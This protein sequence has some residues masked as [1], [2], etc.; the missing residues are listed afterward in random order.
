MQTFGAD[1]V[2]RPL[3]AA[4]APAWAELTAAEQKADPGGEEYS[5]SE[6]AEELAVPGF[7]PATDSLGVFHRDTLVAV[8]LVY[9]K[10]TREP[11]LWY[12]LNGSVHPDHRRSGIGTALLRWQRDRVR[13]MHRDSGSTLPGFVTAGRHAE[14][15]GHEK[16]LTTAGMEPVRWFFDMAC[17]L[18][19]PLVTAPVPAGLRVED[20]P[21]SAD[22]AVRLAYV[23]TFGD[24][25]GSPDADPDYW[26]HNFVEA[27]I[28]RRDLSRLA[29]DGDQ[30]AGYV[31]CFR[32]A[33]DRD[34]Q[35]RERVWLGD[36]GVRRPWRRRGLAAALIADVLARC[37]AAGFPRA[38]LGMD[39][40]NPTGA[41][42]VY[43][44]AGFQVEHR[45]V[46]HG[47]RLPAPADHTW[48]T[49]G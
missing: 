44:R 22:E 39:A 40:D 2:H 23:E 27:G 37:A 29:Y 10:P 17:D 24:H 30:I 25:W 21:V 8:G 6:L 45:W 19:A 18:T 15:A 14:D 9:R 34:D 13:R 1:L 46:T 38:A 36:I 41:L 48:P 33:R 7:D 4:D 5:A 47:E 31:L 28:F 43:Q 35:G 26:R 11:E 49:E 12:R 42:G 16:I 3:T 32:G 20:H